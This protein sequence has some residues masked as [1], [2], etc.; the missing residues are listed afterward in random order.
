MRTQK[1]GLQLGILV[2]GANA[3]GFR[4]TAREATIMAFEVVVYDVDDELFQLGKAGSSKHD[5]AR[6]QARKPTP[7]EELQLWRQ[8]AED[9]TRK[10]QQL[11]QSYQQLKVGAKADSVW[12]KRCNA[13]LTAA[14]RNHR[15]LEFALAAARGQSAQHPAYAALITG[16]E[17][18][19]DNQLQQ[20]HSQGLV[21]IIEPQPSELPDPNLHEVIGAKQTDEL[22]EGL[23]AEVGAAGYLCDGK[24]IRKAKIILATQAGGAAPDDEPDLTADNFSQGD[25]R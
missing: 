25:P 16:I 13:L 11:L 3:A 6:R 12:R 22:V 21:E 1:A 17:Q 4:L 15:D 8:R 23:I 20:L 10:Y 24:V 7:A 9:I 19:I 14:V 2:C 5:S 18:A